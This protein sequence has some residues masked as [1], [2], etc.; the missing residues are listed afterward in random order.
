MEWTFDSRS[1][2]Y[3][4]LDDGLDLAR[5]HIKEKAGTRRPFRVKVLVSFLYFGHNTQRR[6][7]ASRKEWKVTNR[8]FPDDAHAR[9][10]IAVKQNEIA[11]FIQKRENA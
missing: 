6:L 5:I 4:L 10:Y 1:K 7:E 9:R 3:R 2:T 11:D 8:A